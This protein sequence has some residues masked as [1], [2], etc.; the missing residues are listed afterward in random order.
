MNATR[1]FE[2]LN[3][4]WALVC[5]E[6]GRA[7]MVLGGLG[8]KPVE[9]PAPVPTAKGSGRASMAFQRGLM[10]LAQYI[11][12]EGHDHVPRAH[13][14]RIT[15]GGEAEPVTVKLGVWISNTR[16][17]RDKLTQ[18]QRAALAELGAEWAA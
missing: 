12:R 8:V 16:I 5:A 11:A 13:A 4:E 10:A 3:A 14:E 18:E 6:P 2:S 9:R 1:V 17:R 15:V 7:E